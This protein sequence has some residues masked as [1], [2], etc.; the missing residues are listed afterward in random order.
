MLSGLVPL[1]FWKKDSLDSYPVLKLV[2][3]RLEP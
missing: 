1:P 3:F 2:Y